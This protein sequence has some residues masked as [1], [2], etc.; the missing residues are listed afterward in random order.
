MLHEYRIA[1]YTGLILT[2]FV[3]TAESKEAFIEMPSPCY[4][5][6]A[7][8]KDKVYLKEDEK[9]CLQVIKKTLIQID[10]SV[11]IRWKYM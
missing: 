10:D 2:A 7:I 8:K 9:V 1:L 5:V 6:E 11:W 4:S 3:I